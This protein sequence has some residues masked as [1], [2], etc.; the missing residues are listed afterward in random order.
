M[1]FLDKNSRVIDFILTERGKRLFAAGQ[2]DFAYYALFDDGIDYDPVGATTREERQ[3][4][5][6]DT[7]M[8]EV[9]TVKEVRGTVSALE[10]QS[11][12]FTAAPNVRRIPRISSPAEDALEVKCDQVH[13]GTEYE[14]LNTTEAKIDLALDGDVEA[15]NPGFSVRV[16]FSGSDGMHEFSVRRDLTGRRVF[17]PFIAVSLDSSRTGPRGRGR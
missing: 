5:I 10:P 15:G 6:E 9:G 12:L 2:L 1:G 8:L 7:P 4:V 13:F 16:F 17:D 3:E 11:P 14:R